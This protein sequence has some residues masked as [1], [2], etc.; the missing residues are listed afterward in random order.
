[1]RERERDGEKKGESER[2]K[3]TE[4]SENEIGRAREITIRRSCYPD[5]SKDDI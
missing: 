4:R 3:E 2:D 5:L 1:M